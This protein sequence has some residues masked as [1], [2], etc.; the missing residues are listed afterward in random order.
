MARLQLTTLLKEFREV[1]AEMRTLGVSS[2]TNSP[3][4]D[5]ALGA[6]PLPKP[7]LA[8]AEKDPNHARRTYYSELY[9]RPVSDIELKNLP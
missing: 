7:S 5:I 8:K 3:I 9:G 6:P 4:G 2:W 1:V